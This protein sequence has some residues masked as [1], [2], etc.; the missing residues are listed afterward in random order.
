LATLSKRRIVF[1]FS[2]YFQMIDL[3]SCNAET[4]SRRRER[5]HR[6]LG[7]LQW[8]L[9]QNFEPFS[10]KSNFE[11]TAHTTT[12]VMLNLFQHPFRLRHRSQTARWMLKQVQ[13]DV[14]L[15]G[16]VPFPPRP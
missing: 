1:Y 2:V 3:K 6:R 13:H 16:E 7:N 4:E 12:F 5:A 9:S 15:W 8:I 11:V 14:D 10:R